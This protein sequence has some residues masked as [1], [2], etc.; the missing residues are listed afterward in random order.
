MMMNH[1]L[2]MKS[3]YNLSPMQ[4]GMLFHSI[5]NPE[6]ASYF[7]QSSCRINGTLDVDILEQ[8][9][10]ILVDK[11]DV[12][13]TNFLYEKLKYPKQIV[14][15]KRPLNIMYH[16]ISG[17]ELSEKQAYLEQYK[18]IDKTKGFD[19]AREVLLR[20]SVI[21]LS[22]DQYELIWSF[23]HII[24]DGWCLQTVIQEIFEAYNKLKRNEPVVFEEAYPY[25]DYISWLD[26]QDYEEAR[27]FWKQYLDSYET[28]ASLPKSSIEQ[29][30]IS[31][32]LEE[33]VVKLSKDVTEQLK[34]IARDNHVTV[35]SI[36]QT[37]WGVLLSKYNRTND[38]VFGVVTTD[39]PTEIKGVDKIIGLFI[40]TI[41]VR[42]NFAQEDAFSEVVRMV[43]QSSIERQGYGFFPLADI[44]SLSSMKQDLIAHLYT[45]QN[46]ENNSLALLEQ[47]DFRMEESNEFEQT[48]YDFN[49]TIIP[50]DAY[51]IRFEYN[52]YVYEHSTVEKIAGHYQN[53]L[54][55]VSVNPSI[56]MEEIGLL[57][58]EETGQ[59]LDDFNN[60]QMNLSP[61][62]TALQLFEEQV[63]ST[64]DHIAIVFEDQQ[65]TYRELNHKANQ[66]A[67]VLRDNGVK[68]DVLVGIMVERSMVMIVAIIGVMKAGGAYVPIDPSYPEERIKYML[69]DCGTTLLLT[70]RQ[71]F[72]LVPFSGIKLNLDDEGLYS[73]SKNNLER[74]TKPNHLA[75][76]IYTSGSTGKPKGVMVEHSSYISMAFAWKM[77]YHLDRFPVKLLQLA[78]FSFDVFAGDIARTLLFGGQ[79]VICPSDTRLDI[80]G[81]YELINKYSINIFEST[82][83][84]IFPLMEYVYENKFDVSFMKLL[85]LGADICQLSD[86]KKLLQRF[87]HLMRIINSYGVTEATIDSTYYEEKVE[88]LPEIGYTPI[89]KPLPNVRMYVLNA[90]LQ[91]QPVGVVG[92]LCIAGIGVAR[93]YLNKPELTAEK[94]IASPVVRGERVYRTG[95]MARWLPDGNIDFLGRIDHQVKIRGFRIEMGE[96]ESQLLLHPKIQ[97][98]VLVVKEDG[99]GDPFLC[100]YMV[101]TQDMTVA[102]IKDYLSQYLPD[103]MIP[104][105]YIFMKDLPFTPNG[106]VDR[107]A[108]PEPEQPEYSRKNY[109][110]PQHPIEKRLA[111]IWGD[112]LDISRVGLLD[113]FFSLGGHSLKAMTLAAR[114]SKELQT[115]LSLRDIFKASTLNEMANLIR[116]SN[117]SICASIE[118][119][120]KADYYP[121][122]SAQKR[123]LVLNE[124]EQAGTTY[125]MP[126]LLKLEGEFDHGRLEQAF[127]ALVQ[128]HDAFRTSFA[129]IDGEPLQKV[130][131]SIQFNVNY[132][133]LQDESELEQVIIDFVTPFDL[134]QAPL[135][136]IS[137]AK[138]RQGTHYLIGDMHHIISDG[139]SEGILVDEFTK[140]YNG[141]RLNDLSIQYKDYA[142]WQNQIVRDGAVKEQEKYWMKQFEGELPVLNLPTD[143]PRPQL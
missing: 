37:A 97:Q 125:N 70:H 35:N 79:L 42:I 23:H 129:I 119:V 128:R 56:Q 4:Q 120:P 134:R 20:M 1:G 75:Y 135:I 76:V 138:V 28:R 12:L 32:K 39:R 57:T 17:L 30:N 31:Y 127:K 111:E 99:A 15:K 87:G 67:G 54:H 58:K 38:V 95:D 65:M 7:Q 114:I 43:H 61:S 68:P 45:F 89:G 126:F 9:L 105:S 118:R 26:Q 130:H 25:S 5:M 2:E 71:H 131:D 101:C 116:S 29:V 34:S 48:N 59:I 93:G 41:P 133:V 115:K 104:S 13:R 55:T 139:T 78:S 21:Q 86:F 69:E 66:L 36:L 88:A 81:L 73:G 50:N 63:E 80:P 51:E 132:L 18:N 10:N 137:V 102:D 3:I 40:N 94:F 103:Y 122:S 117:E 6:S 107:K 22:D 60:T 142:V 33:T 84:L 24:M 108:L 100:A 64:P 53:I 141:E 121:L 85:I 143:Y 27:H 106:K 72:S 16:D 140:V 19:L 96:I 124:I 14:F 136:R 52:A 109:I 113:N 47:D 49:I 82:P 83:K 46:F 77:E 8:S 62:I 11:H 74:V 92:E 112:V 110:A 123:L 91:L 98:N 44:Q 90:D